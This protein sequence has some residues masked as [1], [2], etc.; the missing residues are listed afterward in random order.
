MRRD[1]RQ[2]KNTHLKATGQLE[3]HAVVETLPDTFSQLCHPSVSQEPTEDVTLSVPALL[4]GMGFTQELCMNST[5]GQRPRE[6]KNHEPPATFSQHRDYVFLQLKH[7]CSHSLTMH[8][9]KLI[10]DK[11]YLGQA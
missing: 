3:N 8:D 7:N 11:P 10:R 5:R 4:V 2:E 1:R 6:E 9:H